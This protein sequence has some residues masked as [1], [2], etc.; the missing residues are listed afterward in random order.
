MSVVDEVSDSLSIRPTEN[1]AE[2]QFWLQVCGRDIDVQT[3]S[4]DKEAYLDCV[5]KMSGL[6]TLE[7]AEFL[8]F[9]SF[10]WVFNEQIQGITH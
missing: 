2:N 10:Q 7:V 8:T 5:R 6:H 9:G 3:L 4:T 1:Y